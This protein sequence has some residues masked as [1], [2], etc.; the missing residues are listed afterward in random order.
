[1]KRRLSSII[2]IF[3]IIFSAVSYTPVLADKKTDA[4]DKLSSIEA[5][6]KAYEAK[7]KELQ[8]Q[9][10]ALSKDKSN[11]DQLRYNLEKKISNMQNQMN[12]VDEQIA[13]LDEKIEQN[14]L[15]LYS[16]NEELYGAK[17]QL[18]ERLRAIYVAGTNSELVILL[19]AQDF[20]DFLARSELLRGVSEHDKKLMDE[21]LSEVN[22]IN[23]IKEENKKAKDENAALKATLESKRTEYDAEYQKASEMLTQITGEQTSLY[24]DT[25]ELASVI[26]QKQ[27]Q[28]EQWRNYIKNNSGDFEFGGSKNDKPSTTKPTTTTT[29]TTTTKPTK[30]TKPM[31]DKNGLTITTT[32]TTTKPTTV[33]TTTKK[34]SASKKELNFAFPFQSL[35]YVSCPYG[36]RENRFHTGIDFSISGALGKPIYAAQSGYVI[37][38]KNMNYSYGNHIIIDHGKKDGKSYST[39]YAHCDTLLVSVG[40]YVERGQQIATC[41]N[42]GNSFGAHLHFEVRINGDYVDPTGYLK[43]P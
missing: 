24:D 7:Q 19:S 1:M 12:F 4:Q 31:T 27:K 16:R 22:S 34:P 28:A 26:A 29:I 21:L 5:E 38:A 9:I 39:L 25:K 2:L 3:A 14:E 41:G 40:D 6:L 35:Y 33:P 18:K 23:I 36:Q 8:L 11:Y 17:T 15:D 10:D 20:S 32:T 30:P 37:L 13:S 42:T 43:F